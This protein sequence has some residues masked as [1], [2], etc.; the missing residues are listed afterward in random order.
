MT[1]TIPVGT[2]EPQDFQLLEG[3][4]PLVG[5]GLDVALV[6]TFSNGIAIGSPGPTVAWLDQAGG[7]VRVTG[8]D[9]LPAGSYS[10]RYSLTD[11][12]GNIGYAPNG[13]VSDDWDVVPV[14]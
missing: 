7:T 14:P 12:V 6:I 8:V 1:Q 4:L 9:L 11:G 5:T 2:S 13:D 3:G 10:V